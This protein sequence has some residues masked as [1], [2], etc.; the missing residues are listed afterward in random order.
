MI[1]FSRFGKTTLTIAPRSTRERAQ[2]AAP[3]QG[4]KRT[5]TS[6]ILYNQ[7]PHSTDPSVPGCLAGAGA[8][9][10]WVLSVFFL[11]LAVVVVVLIISVSFI[12]S[13]GLQQ[14]KKGKELYWF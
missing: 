2:T 1:R 12:C 7:S 14:H 6:T 3:Y 9:T 10:T 11:F 5:T 4:V 13:S 8:M